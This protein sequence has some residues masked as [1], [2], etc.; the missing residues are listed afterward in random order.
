MKAARK[1]VCQ[2][3]RHRESGIEKGKRITRR[4]QPK[5]QK[6]GLQDSRVN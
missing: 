5:T 2:I 6:N 4:K 1:L 3:N